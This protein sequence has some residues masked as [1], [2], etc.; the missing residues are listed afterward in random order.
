[1]AANFVEDRSPDVSA[2][3]HAERDAAAGIEFPRGANQSHHAGRDKVV[4]FQPDPIDQEDLFDFAQDQ[5]QMAL[6]ESANIGWRGGR[7][8][9]EFAY[10]D[11]AFACAGPDRHYAALSTGADLAAALLSIRP[12]MVFLID[13]GISPAPITLI[14]PTR[15]AIRSNARRIWGDTTITGVSPLT[16]APALTAPRIASSIL[17]MAPCSAGIGSPA[18]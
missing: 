7:C 6:G 4:A 15:A 17:A 3:E 12:T 9:F 13:E 14:F 16:L 18:A 11:A 10:R 1:D 5:G 8:R 2:R